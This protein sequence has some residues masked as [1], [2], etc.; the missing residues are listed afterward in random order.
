MEKAQIADLKHSVLMTSEYPRIALKIER[1]CRRIELIDA[2]D[3]FHRI[4]WM[5]NSIQS[6]D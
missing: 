2:A 6:C 1:F 3:K 5:E 4:D